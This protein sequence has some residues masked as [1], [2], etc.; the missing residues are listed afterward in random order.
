MGVTKPADLFQQIKTRPTKFGGY[1]II[2]ARFDKGLGTLMIRFEQI[3]ITR[4]P[5]T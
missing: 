3:F 2:C 1:S 5:L 4:L